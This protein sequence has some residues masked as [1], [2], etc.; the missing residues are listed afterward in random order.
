MTSRHQI[1]AG[2][3]HLLKYSDRKIDQSDFVIL[4]F[5][6]DHIHLSALADHI[7]VFLFLVLFKSAEN[8]A[9]LIS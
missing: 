5:F 8:A 6:I 2:R 3:S 9:V 7:Q 4:F 1:G